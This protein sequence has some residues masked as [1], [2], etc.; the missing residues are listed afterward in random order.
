[1]ANPTGEKKGITLDALIEAFNRNNGYIR[2]TAR[3]LDC[4]VSNVSRRINAAYDAGDTRINPEL[5]FA[6]KIPN[7]YVKEEIARAKAELG[8]RSDAKTKKGD[9]RKASLITKCGTGPIILGLFG[10]PHLDNP[11][12]DLD[13]F[14]EE[15]SRLDPS[16]RVYGACVG[17]MFDNWV[18][19]LQREY[20]SAGDPGAAWALF[21]YWMENHPFLF[22]VSGNHDLWASGS[23][24][25]LVEFM[26]QQG[27]LFRRSGGRFIIDL[28]SGKPITIAMRHIWQGNSQYSEAHNLKRAATFGH[29][30]DDVV[31]GGH[32]HKGECRT[33]IRPSDQKISK[34]VSVSAFKRLDDYAN[35]RGF[36]SADTP[37]VVWM[38][39]DDR[40]PYT[41]HTRAQYF[42]DFDTA[43]AVL[44][45]QQSKNHFEA[46]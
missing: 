33:H 21:Q 4:N 26:R 14:E 2:A 8:M 23:A 11:G 36:M 30:D 34:L 43:R 3:E 37:P 41:S 40:E 39:L 18:G 13:L 38:V 45:H 5:L 16:Q 46:A 20:K 35:D 10:D 15:I 31:V 32:F 1:M 19:F 27:I 9:W 25:F 22:A 29:T 17:D 44:N 28:G 42:Y 12:T 7:G 24:D 6:K